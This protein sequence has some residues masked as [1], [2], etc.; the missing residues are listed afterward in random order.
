MKPKPQWCSQHC[1]LGCR[2]DAQ[3]FAFD[4]GDP[5]TAQILCIWERPAAE[6]VERQE[7]A[8]GNTGGAFNGWLRELGIA[9]DQVLIANTLRCRHPR[10]EFPKE[11]LKADAVKA[12]RHWDEKIAAYNPDVWGVTYH[13]ASCFQVP[14]WK[15][16]VLRAL[17][18][19][20]SY[21]HTGRRPA[22]LMGNE[23]MAAFLPHLKGGV[24]RWKCH[25]EEGL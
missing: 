19:A 3:G 9:R 7:A 23:A 15:P 5:A 22:V 21:R 4:S 14:Q 1:P 18:K 24:G 2:R 6:E 12:C 10:N 20:L 17:D 16:Y 13:P 25:F 11:G 8:V